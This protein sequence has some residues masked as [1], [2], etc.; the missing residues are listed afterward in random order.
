MKKT[1]LFLV[2]ISTTA[3]SMDDDAM[4]NLTNPDR[5]SEQHTLSDQERRS[6]GYSDDSGIYEPPADYRSEPIYDQSGKATYRPV[7]TGTHN[8]DTLGGTESAQYVKPESDTSQQQMQTDQST[9]LSE[10]MGTSKPPK[11]PAP[12]YGPPEPLAPDYGSPKPPALDDDTNQ[13]AKPESGPPGVNRGNKPQDA[14]TPL[15]TDYE[16][17]EPDRTRKPSVVGERPVPLRRAP[18]PPRDP[19]SFS[20]AD[21]TRD[22]DLS[23]FNEIEQAKQQ[24]KNSFAG[25][26]DSE[27]SLST[28]NVRRKAESFIKDPANLQH[29]KPMQDS[30][31]ELSNMDTDFSEYN[32]SGSTDEDELT[33]SD[34]SY[35]DNKINR[36]TDHAELNK[37]KDTLEKYRPIKE[38]LG[39]M[40]RLHN[41]IDD[42]MQELAP[43][44]PPARG[45]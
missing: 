28:K 35:I 21:R 37:I 11:P 10:Q 12:D 24:L 44:R 18:E 9:V 17:P 43:P 26:S 5:I 34:V 27:N 39:E 3:W 14:P 1:F 33:S 7:Q 31:D 8:A 20:M 25:K 13:Y 23:T 38:T 2:V 36:A 4:D 19:L 30:L 22:I 41:R 42:R 29:K 15:A 32:G 40:S 6:S 45:N 16:P